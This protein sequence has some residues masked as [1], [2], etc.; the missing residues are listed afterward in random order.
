M[1]CFCIAYVSIVFHA[2][3]LSQLIP[4]SIEES[5]SFTWYQSHDPVFEEFCIYGFYWL[6][7]SFSRWEMLEYFIQVLYTLLRCL[8]S[9]SVLIVAVDH[10]SLFDALFVYL[11]DCNIADDLVLLSV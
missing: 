9:T 7:F 11:C 10:C 4:V 8:E 6:V 3:S 5:L 2:K 1:Y